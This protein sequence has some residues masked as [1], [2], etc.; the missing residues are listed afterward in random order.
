[1]TM[2]GSG[3]N[4][5]LVACL[6][7]SIAIHAAGTAIVAYQHRAS[8]DAL[9][10]AHRPPLDKKPPE[11][12]EAAGSTASIDW[13]G[14]ESP[15]KHNAAES[16]INQAALALNAG[17]L[18]PITDPLPPA[19]A[20]P[21]APAETAAPPEVPTEEAEAPPAAALRLDP[22]EHGDMPIALRG[23]RMLGSIMAQ[24]RAAIA[25]QARPTPEAE[26]APPQPPRAEAAP[27]PA[28]PTPPAGAAADPGA[29]SDSESDAASR[30]PDAEAPLTSGAVVSAAG[31]EITT[32]K[33]HF[34]TLTRLTTRPRNPLVRIS[35]NRSGYAA[36]VELLE[37]SGFSGVDDPIVTAVYNWTAAGE[38]LLKLP[39]NDPEA[40][41]DVTIRILLR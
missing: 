32:R 34:E 27:T 16:E 39:A 37:S 29:P 6:A 33:P 4:R 9:A 24:L 20:Q 7:A 13:I 12:G 36:A 1:M 38:P 41:V 22:A 31:L 28:P 14:F 15:L 21:D 19:P 8:S 25:A 17:P 23:D 10:M 3:T 5:R 26:P 18:S 35:F 40:T 11:L 2:R 30:E